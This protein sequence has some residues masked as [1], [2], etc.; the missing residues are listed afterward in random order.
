MDVSRKCAD[1]LLM[2]ALR[3][4]VMPPSKMSAIVEDVDF[5][6]RRHPEFEPYKGSVFGL[7]MAVTEHTKG[8]PWLAPKRCEKLHGI[9]DAAALYRSA[10]LDVADVVDDV[11]DVEWKEAA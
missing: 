8:S 3:A 6:E 7:Y 4:G 10:S 2:S 5:P 9:L 1:H 11:E